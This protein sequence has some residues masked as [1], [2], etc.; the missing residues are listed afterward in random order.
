M[1]RLSI[2]V[3]IFNAEKYLK[4]CLD[5]LLRQSLTDFELILVDDGSTDSSGSIC[6]Q[7]AQTDARVTVIHT[8]NCGALSA[9]RTGIDRA[10]SEY[11]ACVDSDDWIERDLYLDAMEE[12]ERTQPDVLVFA[13]VLRTGNRVSTTWVQPGIYSGEALKRDVHPRMLYDKKTNGFGFTPCLWDKIFRTKLLREIHQTIDSSITLGEDAACSYPCLFKADRI[14]VFANDACYNYRE[15]HVSMVNQCDMKLLQRVHALTVQMEH[16]FSGADAVV[17]DQVY[18]YIASAALYV[19]RQ[20][21][22]YN[23]SMKLWD[24]I[25]AVKVFAER[26]E[27]RRAFLAAK[28]AATNR[29]FRAK[30]GLVLRSRMVWLTLLFRVNGRGKQ[31]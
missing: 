23:R 4:T 24:R 8:E 17:S 25:Q 21:L 19:M 7:Y 12:V 14:C 27:L 5:S 3:P 2:V 9:R 29:K 26:E 1:P 18:C 13:Y 15:G 10:T 22:L 16:T 31:M 30:I 6:D 20:V 11:T 28:R